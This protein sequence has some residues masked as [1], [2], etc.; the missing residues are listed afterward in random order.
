MWKG[1]GFISHV[2]GEWNYWTNLSPYEGM[3]EKEKN[4]HI[5]NMKKAVSKRIKCVDTG[6]EFASMTEAARYYNIPYNSVRRSVQNNK[7]VFNRKNNNYYQFVLCDKD[8][9]ISGDVEEWKYIDGS[10]NCYVSSLGNLRHNEE[11]IRQ[12]YDSEGYLRAS[13]IGV[14]RKRVHQFVA[15][16]FVENPKNKPYINHINGIKDDNRA[17][18]LEWVTPKE[19]SIHAGKQGL[20]SK[21]DTKFGKIVAIL[22]SSKE[23][24]IFENQ[25]VAARELGIDDSEV[26]KCLKGKRN[27]SHGYTFAYL[28]E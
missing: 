27:T 13:V 6:E 10:E 12:F 23:A 7:V 11:T 5:E 14:G 22:V 8:N 18:N 4:R 17:E 25:S 24:Q 28:S 20:L 2:V 15:G 1:G 26:N 21:N 9:E 3:S 16:C 19:N